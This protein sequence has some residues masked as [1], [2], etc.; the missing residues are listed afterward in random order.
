ML[1]E[2][3]LIE[4]CKQ[5]SYSAQLIVYENYKGMM[6]NTSFRI[7]QSREDA[8]DIMQESFLVAFEK[9]GQLKESV[10]LGGW[11][12]RIV[13]NRSLDAVRKKKRDGWTEALNDSIQQEEDN[14]QEEDLSATIEQIKE[15]I[16]NLKEKYRIVLVLNLIEGYNLKEIASFLKLKE[17]TVRNQ[18]S[19]GKKQLILK[20]K[21]HHHEFR[22]AH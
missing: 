17:S 11:L 13:I 12:K 19:R 22:E 6:L 5:N 14:V 1:N 21:R 8:E 3:E 4:Q 20:L 18:F 10:S 9:I 2:L 7:V 16:Y 15:G